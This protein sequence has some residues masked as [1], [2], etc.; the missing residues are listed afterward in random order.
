MRN[1]VA[2]LGAK[3]APRARV[4]LRNARCCARAIPATK[5]LEKSEIICIF[6]CLVF[7][8]LLT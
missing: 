6:D 1:E 8:F 2:F 7:L 3:G 5:N 4:P